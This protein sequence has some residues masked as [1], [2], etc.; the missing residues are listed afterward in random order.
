MLDAIDAKVDG[1]MTSEE[2]KELEEFLV[3]R[4]QQIPQEP[5]EESPKDEAKE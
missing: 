1:I 2:L 3:A 4:S 5:A